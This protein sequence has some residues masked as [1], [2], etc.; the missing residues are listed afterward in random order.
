MRKA[1]EKL[2]IYFTLL[3][4][5]KWVIFTPVDISILPCEANMVIAS[6]NLSIL[7]ILTSDL[8]SLWVKAQISEAIDK[9]NVKGSRKGM[10]EG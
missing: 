6:D 8:D 3:K 10:L 4:I 9:V 5:A 1:L 2:R 7:G